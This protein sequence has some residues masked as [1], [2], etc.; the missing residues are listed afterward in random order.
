M[1]LV[2]PDGFAKVTASLCMTSSMAWPGW[3]RISFWFNSQLIGLL[4]LLCTNWWR[5]EMPSG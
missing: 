5:M 1:V 3:Q 4:V 2:W